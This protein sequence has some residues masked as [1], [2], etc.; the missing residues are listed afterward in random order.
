MNILENIEIIRKQKGIKQTVIAE[1]LGVKQPAYS[2]Y[3]TRSADIPFNRLLQICNVLETD[4]I[5][6]IKY[7]VKYV[8]ET[9]Q[10]EQCHDYKE[11][12]KS[13]NNYIKTLEKNQ[14]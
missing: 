3:I 10:C 14:N 2:N 1:M 6:V 8:P 9:E 11:I 12:I 7:P 5:N 13:L 4:V